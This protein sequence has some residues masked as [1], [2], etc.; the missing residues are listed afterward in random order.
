MSSGVTIETQAA[1]GLFRF[2]PIDVWQ[3]SVSS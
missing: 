1:G 2:R 3:E